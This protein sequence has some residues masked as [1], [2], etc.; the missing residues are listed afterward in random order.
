[1]SRERAEE[2]Q[3]A[4]EREKALFD[5]IDELSKKVDRLNT[6]P[7]A[8]WVKGVAF[9]VFMFVWPFIATSAWKLVKAFYVQKLKK[10]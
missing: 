2:H 6:T 5:K 4:K 8:T 1:M 10:Q 7:G 3:R 9:G